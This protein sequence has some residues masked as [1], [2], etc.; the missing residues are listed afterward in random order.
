MHTVV[1]LNLN[2]KPSVCMVHSIGCLNWA[3]QLGSE[4]KTACTSFNYFH[5]ILLK[6]CIFCSILFL[7]NL[8]ATVNVN[9]AHLHALP[10]FIF[11]TVHTTGS[12]A[13]LF[14][15][16]GLIPTCTKSNLLNSHTTHM[17]YMEF[18][19]P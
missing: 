4:N 13:S 17:H 10:S 5:H 11:H 3:S 9:S 18:P 15:H 7:Y 2:P 19:R 16:I 1:S 8:L 14:T 12:T 6:L